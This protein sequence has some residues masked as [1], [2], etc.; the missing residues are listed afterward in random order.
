ME[1]DHTP[2]SKQKMCPK[3]PG[4]PCHCKSKSTTFKATEASLPLRQ[5]QPLYA[6][7]MTKT[8]ASFDTGGMIPLRF[9]R[10]G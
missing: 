4:M 2:R 8:P 9:D 5:I 7:S 6:V 3:Y 10:P 1:F